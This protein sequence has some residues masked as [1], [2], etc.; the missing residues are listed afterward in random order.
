MSVYD[1]IEA[2]SAREKSA[3]P[4][5][6]GKRIR[7]YSLGV[8]AKLHQAEF[9]LKMITDSNAM[10]DDS[11]NMSY[12]NVFPAKDR[13]YFY[14]DAFFA[15][16]YSAFDIV[17]HVINS[18]CRLHMK[19]NQIKFCSINEKLGKKKKGTKIQALYNK[20]SAKRYFK[21]L[22][23]YRNCSTH[24]RQIYLETRSETLVDSTQGYDA[25]AELT[26]NRTFICDDPLSLNPKINKNR[27]L[28]KYCSSMLKK[29]M[30][31]IERIYQTI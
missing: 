2:V 7:L 11:M 8:G 14:V 12:P 4:P 20:I 21:E 22:K 16:L 25:S 19:E 28:E 10:N 17:S 24:R 30:Q 15:F 23:K 6:V 5:R 27:E 31:E 29:V 1:T 26:I 18:K 3:Q 13:R 9:A